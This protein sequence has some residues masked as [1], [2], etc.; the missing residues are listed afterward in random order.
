[1]EDS[2]EYLAAGEDGRLAAVPS[3]RCDGCGRVCREPAAPPCRA[4]PAE[5]TPSAL[6]LERLVEL[7][8]TPRLDARVLN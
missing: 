2:R 4:S 1:M 3:L 6:L 5:S 7:L 8:S